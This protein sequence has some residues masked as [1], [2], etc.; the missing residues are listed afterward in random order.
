M[1]PSV[2]RDTA[3]LLVI[4]ALGRLGMTVVSY[5]ESHAISTSFLVMAVLEFLLLGLV[6][7][8]V[9]LH[10]QERR[11]TQQAS[12]AKNFELTA[13]NREIERATRMKSQFLASMSHELRTPLNSIL[14]FSELLEEQA[15]G[16]LNDK[17]QR[18]IAHVRT[19]ARHLLRLINDVLDL[20]KIEAGHLA[21]QI[22]EFPMGEALP[23]V[24]SVIKPLA[25]TKKVAVSSRLNGYIVV[26]G[27]RVRVKQVLYNLVN[28]A[29]KFTP[30]GGKVEVACN[31][32]SD[33]AV[34]TV[35][36]TGI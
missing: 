35:S 28:N 12:E 31:I 11:R 15:A 26:R 13:R 4:V 18:W 36:D 16:A 32:A 29:V 27:D 24:L 7:L 10:F 6:Y 21:L 19:A 14:G 3:V 5:R 1:M 34:I 30:A 8:V 9:V 20:S 17:Q 22:E 25:M 23:E 33:Q 2:Q